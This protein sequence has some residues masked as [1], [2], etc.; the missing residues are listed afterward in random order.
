MQT[1]ALL[2]VLPPFERQRDIIVYGDQSMEQ[3]IA[4]VLNAHNRY[5]PHYDRIGSFF[6]GYAPRKLFDFVQRNMTYKEEPG[7]DQKTKSPS[8]ALCSKNNDCKHYAGFI[9]GILDAINR[10]GKK[11][12][13]WKYRFAEYDN[14]GTY[15]HVYITV[16]ND[17]WI[18]P[19]PIKN[20][21]TG[22][23]ETRTF[24]DRK[25]YP[26]NWID[27]KPR[28]ML[29]SLHGVQYTVTNQL[30]PTA[31]CSGAY[32]GQTTSGSTTSVSPDIAAA[33]AADPE[34]GAVV[35]GAQ[36]LANSLPDGSLKDW[37]ND[38]LSDPT[39]AVKSIIFGR[40]YNTGNYKL[41]EIYM[42]NI[43]G[44][45]QIQRNT[46]VPDK[47][48]PQ[49]W[50]FFT[51]AMGVPVGSIDHMDALVQGRDAYKTWANGTFSWVPDDQVDRA[52]KI[53]N[54]YIGWTPSYY[55][56]DVA[57]D[58]TKFQAI[59]YIYPV[60]A[61]WDGS[62][63]VKKFTGKHPITGQNF[64]DGFPVG[65]SSTP[66][67][68]GIS[69]VNNT[70]A[71]IGQV[72]SIIGYNVAFVSSENG[73][74]PMNCNRAVASGWEDFMIGDAGN[75]KVWLE[76]SNMY[77]SV[78]ASKNLWC[79]KTS[80]T[81]TEAFDWIDNGDGTFS[82]RGSNGLYVTSNNGA[83]SMT[84]DRSTI[85]G[86]EKFKWAVFRDQMTAASVVPASTPGSGPTTQKA[87][88]GL[89]GGIV[90]LGLAGGLLYAANKKKHAR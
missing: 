34:V 61:V 42:R 13:D 75:G 63:P 58:L 65:V 36:T 35:E 43:L 84:C 89:V 45:E 16:G 25:I 72:I 23:Y 3:I 4:E 88:F 39:G 85:G 82:L 71:P 14:K 15:D 9:G 8:A 28:T 22:L 37:V 21:V 20:K 67:G 12:Y 19:T 90:L 26:T 83:S 11:Y 81:A 56:R 66:P 60:W 29:S 55:P 69:P 78:D 57:W 5:A 64:T 51:A 50:A 41:G 18:D 27:I 70:G 52:N 6:P 2:N 76:N 73:A 77:V 86:W 44:M 48:I 17:L 1:D 32:I 33:A 74:K 80:V 46:Q 54:Q 49:A 47:Y 31:C 79:N 59:P 87:G 40:T 7:K 30:P 10:T 62:S 24:N 38:F 53:L 68:T